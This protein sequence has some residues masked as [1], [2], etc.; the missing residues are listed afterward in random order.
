MIIAMSNPFLFPNL[1]EVV[2]AGH[3]A[4]GQFAHRYAAMSTVAYS[5]PALQFRYVTAN[6]S[7]YVYLDSKRPTP[8]YGWP[9]V[10]PSGYP[11]YD[12]YK[13]GLQNRY[14]YAAQISS[15]QIKA[16]YEARHVIYLLG[17]ND[18][19]RDDSLD[20]SPAADLQGTHRLDRGRFYYQRMLELFPLNRH[21]KI[22]VPNIGHTNQIYKST[23][24][25]AALFF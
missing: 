4:G 22:V 15:T 11:G 12:N 7:S 23:Q 2:I 13:Y 8:P 20:D 9:F 17:A 18:T 1:R 10:V 19:L 21:R 14:G 5:R 16:Q 6:P 25:R 3:S 24:G